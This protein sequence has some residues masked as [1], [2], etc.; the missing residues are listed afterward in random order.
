MKSAMC[1]KIACTCGEPTRHHVMSRRVMQHHNSSHTTHRAVPSPCR[2]T[3]SP[4]SAAAARAGWRSTAPR[5]AACVDTGPSTALAAARGSI[6]FSCSYYILYERCMV[7]WW[8]ISIQGE[9]NSH[10]NYSDIFMSQ[11]QNGHLFNQYVNCFIKIFAL[12][13]Q[14]NK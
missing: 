13:K 7:T 12:S 11:S 4:C 3:P 5:W 8:C 9:M 6:V 14:T 1:S 10:Y 2:Y